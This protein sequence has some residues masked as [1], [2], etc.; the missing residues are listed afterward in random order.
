[1][2][3]LKL[4]NKTSFFISCSFSN[5]TTK[6]NIFCEIGTYQGRNLAFFFTS[7]TICCTK[8]MVLC[9]KLLKKCHFVSKYGMFFVILRYIVTKNRKIWH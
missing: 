4:D 8:Y 7:S 9:N 2:E 5:L 1:M 3:V 6:I